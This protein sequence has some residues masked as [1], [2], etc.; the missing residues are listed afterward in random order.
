MM[1]LQAGTD[2][3]LLIDTSHGTAC[4]RNRLG[5]SLSGPFTWDPYPTM[6]CDF[7]SGH[8]DAH[9]MEM[10]DYFR[11]SCRLTVIALEPGYLAV[12]S[13]AILHLDQP[14]TRCAAMSPQRRCVVLRSLACHG[15]GMSR[16]SQDGKDGVLVFCRSA[17][18]ES[19]GSRD[20]ASEAKQGPGKDENSLFKRY[21]AGADRGGAGCR[22]GLTCVGVR[23]CRKMVN[24]KVEATE[25]KGKADRPELDPDNLMVGG[26]DRCVCTHRRGCLTW[27]VAR[28]L[29][30]S[31][32]PVL[33]AW[34]SVWEYLE[35][36]KEETDTPT[37][38]ESCMQAASSHSPCLLVLLMTAQRP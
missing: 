11:A 2:I 8:R 4:F 31:A 10:D 22:A 36:G 13:V 3:D 27:R 26:Y 21:D 16:Y 6:N 1:L 29:T 18:T 20:V 38:S 7:D 9:E 17:Y 12:R 25:G 30:T 19:G 5:P 24:V 32:M 14:H 23:V 37:R 28:G 34:C 35:E 15:L 33:W